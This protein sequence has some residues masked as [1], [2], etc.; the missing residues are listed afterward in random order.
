MQG[1]FPCRHLRVLVPFLLLAGCSSRY[2]GR[3]R[4]QPPSPVPVFAGDLAE[5]DA[6]LEE[7]RRNAEAGGL[8]AGMSEVIA[9]VLDGQLA[10]TVTL[11]DGRAA[12]VKG[13]LADRPATLVVPA[14]M[15][16]LR[17]LRAAVAD[18]KLDEQEIFNFAYVLFVPCLKRIHAM[19]YFTQ[20]GDKTSFGVDNF[21]HFTIKNPQGLTYHGQKVVVGA[22][23]LTADGF[24]FHLPGLT[25]DPDVRYEFTLPE[26]LSL[27]TL[28][29]Y[30]AERRRNNPLSLLTLGNDVRDRLERAITYT[31]Q[32]H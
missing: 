22:T 25:G 28:L 18:G 32:W 8:L 16:Q 10:Y 12:I 4:P 21:M 29:V 9:V 5:A 24:F 11:A 2:V 19:F 7:T 14:T 20:P 26:A 17:N 23:V 6:L 31:R 13:A 15:M 3:I 27:Y 1:M 30:E